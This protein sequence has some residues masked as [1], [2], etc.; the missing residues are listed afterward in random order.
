M[1][2]ADEDA[3]QCDFAEFYHVFNWRALPVR[4]AATLAFGLPDCSRTKLRLSGFELPINTMLIAS[5][6]DAL[7]LLC[8]M[9]SE[10]GRSGTNRPKSVLDAITRKETG[11]DECGFESGEAFEAARAKILEGN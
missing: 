6:V 7:N 10:D 5:A 9:Q 3:L 11:N 8:W 4:F 2:A 1:V